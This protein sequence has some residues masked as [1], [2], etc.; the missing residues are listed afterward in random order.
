MTKFIVISPS[1]LKVPACVYP[2]GTLF[3]KFTVTLV[4]E[5]RYTLVDSDEKRA[6]LLIKLVK[7]DSPPPMKWWILAIFHPFICS[8]DM[9]PIVYSYMLSIIYILIIIDK[10][11]FILKMVRGS[12]RLK[13][14]WKLTRLSI[15]FLMKSQLHSQLGNFIKF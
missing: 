3:I 5:R 10:S 4:T 9:Q 8:S 1:S 6:R 15:E 7:I 12:G 13:L 11:T 2:F 14:V